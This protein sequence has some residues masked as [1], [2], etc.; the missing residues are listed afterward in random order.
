MTKKETKKELKNLEKKIGK[1]PKFFKELTEKDPEMFKFIMRFEQHI[2]DD[3]ALSRKIKKLIAISI[4]AAL[5]DQHAVHAH[6]LVR[7]SS[8]LQKRRLRR[9]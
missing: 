5:R 6:W 1:V 8:G 4:A 3:G 2:W 9:R 7:Q